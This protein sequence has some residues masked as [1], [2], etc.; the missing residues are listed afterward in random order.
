MQYGRMSEEPGVYVL[1]KIPECGNFEYIFKNKHFFL[2]VDQFGPS[3][4]QQDPPAGMFVLQRK[5][6]ETFSP[7]RYYFKDGSKMVHNF[8][9]YNA[10]KFEIRYFPYKAEYELQFATLN[11]LTTIVVDTKIAAFYMNIKVTQK[12]DEMTKCLQIASFDPIDTSMAIWDKKEWYCSTEVDG[13]NSPMFT[14]KH[15]SVNGNKNERR[16]IVLLQDKNVTSLQN[17]SEKLRYFSRN[18]TIMPEKIANTELE[19]VVCYDQICSSRF[20]IK[21]GDEINALVMVVNSDE[22]INKKELLKSLNY[23]NINKIVEENKVEYLSQINRRKIETPDKQFNNFINNYL[24]LELSWVT[25]L[26]RGWPT[27]MRGARDCANDFLGYLAYDLPKCRDV[28]ATLF[29]NERFEDGWFPRQIPFGDSNKYDLRPFSDSGAFVIELVYEYLCYSNDFSLLDET[30]TYFGKEKTGTGLEHLIKAAQYYSMEEHI[31][32]HGLIK[33][34]GGDWLDC[35]N[36]VG[37]KGRGETLMVTCQ[38]ILAFK[39][40]CEV[41]RKYKDKYLLEIKEFEKTTAKF[42]KAIKENCYLKDETFYKA[43]FSD[44]GNWYFSNK[45]LDNNKRIYIPSNAYTIISEINPSVDKKII[46]TI[47]ENNES[48]YG[49]K[50]FTTPFGNPPFEGIGKMATGDFYPYM[51]ENGAVYNH[52]GNLFYARALAVAGDYKTMYRAINYALPY[53]PKFHPESVTCLP[54]YACTNA[55][56]LVPTFKGRS[57]LC[58]L[59]G[60]IAMIERSVF[61]WMFGLDYHIDYLRI[62]PCI[63]A[64][65]KDSVIN[66]IYCGHKIEIKYIGY[67]NKVISCT[68]N[69]ADIVVKNNDLMIEKKLLQKDIK[70]II[71]LNK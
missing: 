48:E 32:E 55:Y 53:N 18:L 39:Q 52:G 25:D 45:D 14:V 42:K 10:K 17:S 3:L 50:L 65:Y 15:Y 1:N 70:L 56:N 54:A 44:D 58:F 69:N 13:K 40:V 35:L 41:L 6:R 27:G 71:K 29:N 9:I 57:G 19:N 64:Q 28:I 47:N 66:E 2:K 11:V 31:G 59:T 30:F 37:L 4:I 22:N 24:P 68:L 38:A 16:N 33:L 34:N 63:P 7:I 12:K 43:L 51:F 5:E 23:S 46:K 62:K 49:F 26:D 60:S 21:N 20:D 67:G 36:R 8:D 61:N